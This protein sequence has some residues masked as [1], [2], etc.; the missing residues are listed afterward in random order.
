MADRF[1]YTNTALHQEPRLDLL[2]PDLERFGRLDFLIASDVFEHID[3]PVERAFENALALLAPGGLLVLT[4]PYRAH[5][6]TKEHFPDLH[7]YRLVPRGE[8]RLVLENITADGRRETFEDLTFHGGYGHTLEL[9]IF[10]LPALLRS[11]EIAGFTAVT[12]HDRPCHA[13]G[14]WWPNGL[15]YPVTARR[16]CP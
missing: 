8:E 14:V 2:D 3:P 12:A 9:R 6:A 5:G 1:D 13:H 15:S 7:D 16:P 4:V 11:L 10:A